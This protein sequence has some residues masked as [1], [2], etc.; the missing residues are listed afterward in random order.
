MIKR[1]N[2]LDIA[3]TQMTVRIRRSNMEPGYMN[4]RY[5][6]HMLQKRVDK[7]LEHLI[8]CSYWTIGPGS[9]Y[10]CEFIKYMEGNES[11]GAERS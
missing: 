5:R 9:R 2:P 3:L 1:R 11:G 8:N 6:K 7:M 4:R 10:H